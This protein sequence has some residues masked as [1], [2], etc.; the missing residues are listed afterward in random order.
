MSAGISYDAAGKMLLPLFSN[1]AQNIS[2]IGTVKSLTGPVSR[3][4]TEIIKKHLAVLE[5]MDEEYKVLYNGLA[6]IA[7]RITVERGGISGKKAKEIINLIG[8]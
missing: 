5:S 6:R 3:G 4:D 1:T 7:L 8:E 2:A